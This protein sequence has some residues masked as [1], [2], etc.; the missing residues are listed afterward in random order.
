M[1]RG[2]CIDPRFLDLDTSWKWAVR[3]TPRPLYPRYPL[4]GGRVGPRAGLDDMEKWKFLTLLRLELRIVGRP[5]DGQS[6]R[7]LRYR[8]S[9]TESSIMT[10]LFGSGTII[11]IKAIPV[12]GLGGL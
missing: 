11:S 8:R 12:T 3:F 7:K 4:V 10:N 2:G 1:G 5:V 6:Q 9:S